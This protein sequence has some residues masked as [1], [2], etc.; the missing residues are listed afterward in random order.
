MTNSSVN[1]TGM[2]ELDVA[3]LRERLSEL[4]HEQWCAWSKSLAETERL[5]ADRSEA[6]RR[7]WRPYSELPEQDKEL[8]REY[9]DRV[10]ELLRRLAILP[11][12]GGS[13]D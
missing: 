5:S 3:A 12:E 9:A 4:E 11:A 1:G 10:I 8:D 13:N 2:T 6:W 7:R